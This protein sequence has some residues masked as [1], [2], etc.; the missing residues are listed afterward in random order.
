MR[1]ELWTPRWRS[2]KTVGGDRACAGK[3]LHSS[4]GGH[5]VVIR[6][7][8]YCVCLGTARIS[9]DDQH[10]LVDIGLFVKVLQAAR[11]LGGGSVEC[12]IGILLDHGSLVGVG[13]EG[14]HFLGSE[15]GEGLALEHSQ[16][17][18]GAG[19]GLTP[20]FFGGILIGNHPDADQAV[21]FVQEL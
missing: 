20:R 7:Q 19:S 21:G 11:D 4:V 3:L 16:H 5:A 17:C 2:Q 12:P 9:P 18:H 8:F 13:L 10:H 1:H 14:F 6:D 15:Q